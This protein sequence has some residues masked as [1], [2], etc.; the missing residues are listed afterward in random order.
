MGTKSIAPIAVMMMTPSPF[1]L[2]RPMNPIR[3]G[4]AAIAMAVTGIHMRGLIR[5]L[6]ALSELEPASDPI[7]VRQYITAAIVNMSIM[8]YLGMM[9][10]PGQSG[11]MDIT[12]APRNTGN[13]DR[14]VS[15]AAKS[16]ADRAVIL[17]SW[18]DI[19][20]ELVRW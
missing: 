10:I 19:P 2:P 6:D 14:R 7:C 16:G 3:I 12:V 17:Q 13:A 11:I 5:S 20:I 9:G 18:M 1:L 8:P 15:S 4:N